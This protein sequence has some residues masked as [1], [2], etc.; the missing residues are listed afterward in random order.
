[1]RTKH[2]IFFQCKL[3][4][5]TMSE[6]M[7]CVMEE[8]AWPA[9]CYRFCAGKR[10]TCINWYARVIKCYISKSF[11]I[12]SK[13]QNQVIDNTNGHLTPHKIRFTASSGRSIAQKWKHA[14]RLDISKCGANCA[15]SMLV[16]TEICAQLHQALLGLRLPLR[17]SFSALRTEI[18]LPKSSIL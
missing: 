9:K 11:E 5:G 13:F 1:M 14:A 16:N 3:Q 6:I 8:Y 10:V 12:S 7:R 18:L 4:V 17:R 15:R 2:L